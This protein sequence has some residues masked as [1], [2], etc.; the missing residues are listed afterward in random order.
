MYSNID[1]NFNQNQNLMQ[2]Q[3]FCRGLRGRDRIVVCYATT[4][5]ISVYHHWSYEFEPRSLRVVLDATLYD[6]LSVTCDRSVVFSGY[7]GFFH[8]WNWPPRYNWNIVESGVKHHKPKPNININV[9]IK[10]HLMEM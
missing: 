4:C 3:L 1:V 10:H 8:Q 6:N 5:A 7:S 9:V 2:I